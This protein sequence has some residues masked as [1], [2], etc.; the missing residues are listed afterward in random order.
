MEA[1]WN[2]AHKW[3]MASGLDAAGA[4]AAASALCAAATVGVG[5]G[6]CATL[7]AVARRLIGKIDLPK[8]HK[9]KSATL[10]RTATW[11]AFAWFM[12]AWLPDAANAYPAI[13]RPMSRILYIATVILFTS[14]IASVITWLRETAGDHAQ[15]QAFASKTLSQMAKIIF[16]LDF[17]M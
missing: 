11:T 2:M 15:R 7:S 12:F 3:A 14:S 16:Q 1:I 9:T 8:P 10:I 17:I 5:G 6:I 4:K 13:S